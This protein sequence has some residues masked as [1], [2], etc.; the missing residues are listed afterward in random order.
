MHRIFKEQPFYT[1]L[2]LVAGTPVVNPSKTGKLGFVAIAVDHEESSLKI[3]RKI[4]TIL[5]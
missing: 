2:S 5:K 4:I 3:V 1:S